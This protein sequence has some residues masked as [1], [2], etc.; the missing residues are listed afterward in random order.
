MKKLN[1]LVRLGISAAA[2]FGALVLAAF[3]VTLIDLYMTGHGYPSITREVITWDPAGVHMSIGD[4]G[5]LSAMVVAA[6]SIWY[7]TGLGRD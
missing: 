6:V 7:L 2:G 4:V 3:V 5:M 1:L